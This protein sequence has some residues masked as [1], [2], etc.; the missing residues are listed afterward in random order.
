MADSGRNGA[1]LPA[2]THTI[3]A[4]NVGGLFY[5]VVPGAGSGA[6]WRPWDNGDRQ[7]WRGKV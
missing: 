4:Q 5:A 7:G 1:P 3:V 6:P 2:L